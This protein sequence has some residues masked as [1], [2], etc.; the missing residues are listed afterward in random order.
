MRY[1]SMILALIAVFLLPC[2]IADAQC[3]GGG[4]SSQVNNVLPQVAPITTTVQSR[5]SLRQID[6]LVRLRPAMD[7][8]AGTSKLREELAALRVQLNERA[9]T[10]VQKR[11]MQKSVQP[12]SADEKIAALTVSLDKLT[13][14]VTSIVKVQGEMQANRIDPEALATAVS[15]RVMLS[16]NALPV[17][18]QIEDPDTGETF[19]QERLLGE[20]DEKPFSLAFVE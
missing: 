9:D 16:V 10:I 13:A 1:V 6:E 15:E 4:C 3:S 8:G 14:A 17:K 2:A 19:T 18:M 7:N 12:V 5:G 11:A 20:M